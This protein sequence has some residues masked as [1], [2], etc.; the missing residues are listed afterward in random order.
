MV[1]NLFQII[2]SD[3]RVDDDDDPVSYDIDGDDDDE[4]IDY[5]SFLLCNIPST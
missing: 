1:P 3:Y 2:F 5:G 4:E